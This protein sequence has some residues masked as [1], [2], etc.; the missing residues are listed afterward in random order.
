MPARHLSLN[1]GIRAHFYQHGA[2]R[3]RHMAPTAHVGQCAS[4]TGTEFHQS[5]CGS[6]MHYIHFIRSC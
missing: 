2:Q 4:G 5:G 1:D 6:V 3:K